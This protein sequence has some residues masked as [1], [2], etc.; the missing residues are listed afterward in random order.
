MKAF[1]F[2][3]YRTLTFSWIS[4]GSPKNTIGIKRSISCNIA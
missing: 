1:F 3:P 4:R 2:F